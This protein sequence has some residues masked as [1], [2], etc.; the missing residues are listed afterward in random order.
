MQVNEAR[1]WQSL[2]DLANLTD[3]DKPYTRR[4]FSERFLQGREWLSAQMHALGMRTHIDNAGNLIGRLAGNGSRAGVIAIGSH[5]D[6]V[7]SGGRFDGIAGVLA[8]L[9]C[10]RTWQDNGITLNHDVEIIDYLAEEPS[11]WG[12]SCIGS[13]GITGFLDDAL[14][15]TPHPQTGETLADAIRRM[16][17][18]PERL[19]K[20]DDIVAAFE[21]HIEQG[22]VLESEQLAVG[23]VSGIVGIIRL[24]LT[25]CGQA[26][27]AGTTPM[28]LRQDAVCA[29]AD[30]VLAAEALA[31]EM[32]AANEG[33]FVAT[34]GQ[35]FAHPNASNVIA[36]RCRLVFDIRS[37][38]K[39]L[40][41]HFVAR[42]AETVATITSRRGVECRD[43]QRLTDTFPVL[44]DAGLMRHLTQA[45]EQL[46]ISHRVM[47][48]GAGHDAAFMAHIAPMA[49]VFVPSK[50]GI[51][52][53]PAE[54][55][56][57]DELAHGAAV[58]CTAVTTFDKE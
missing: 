54:W 46:A 21:L 51:S 39:A 48:S 56:E 6:T 41:E 5:S 36:G 13:R 52:H 19:I 10:V 14:L 17:G 55:T 9:E 45:A 16:G 29:A 32:V 42:L 7:P 4:S 12:M 11:E 26:N 33:Y 57:K 15:A 3:P 30:V 34:C 25:L 23:I 38:N 31:H 35:V 27:H 47:P 28:A 53:N 37:D 40:M 49:M 20:R 8:G 1:L 24:E 18:N 2:M 22:R 58:L 43:W 50:D 44:S